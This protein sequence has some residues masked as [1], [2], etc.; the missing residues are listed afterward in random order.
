MIY[1][2]PLFPS[3]YVIFIYF[4]IL[5]I[6][7]HAYWLYLSTSITLSCPSFLP[8]HGIHLLYGAILGTPVILHAIK[9]IP[10]FREDSIFHELVCLCHGITRA[11][12][13]LHLLE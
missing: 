4:H 11:R 8:I 7:I 1:S 10:L 13:H 2:F 6:L 3:Y 12:C 5:F 9:E